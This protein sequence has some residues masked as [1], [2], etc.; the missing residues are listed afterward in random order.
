M[1]KFLLFT[2]DMEYYKLKLLEK[3]IFNNFNKITEI[4]NNDTSNNWYKLIYCVTIPNEVHYSIFFYNL[5]LT[6]GNQEILEYYWNDSSLNNGE[7]VKV[8][9]NIDNKLKDLHKYLFL[10]IKDN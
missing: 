3:N 1:P 4:N 5:K 7:I 8:S 6:Y 2:L 10:Y 9:N